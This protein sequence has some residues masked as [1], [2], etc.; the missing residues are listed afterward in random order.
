MKRPNLGPSI[1]RVMK[2]VFASEEKSQAFL[3]TYASAKVQDFLEKANNEGF[4]WDDCRHRASS[5]N[6]E[7]ELLWQCVKFSRF[8]RQ[9]PTPILD[10]NGRP[11]EYRL[12][13]SAHRVLHAIDLNLGGTLQ[14]LTPQLDS[15]EDRQRWLMTSLQEEAITSSMIEGAVVTR[16]AAKEMLRAGRKPRDQSEQMVLNNFETIRWLNDHRDDDLTPNLLRTIQS[17][18]TEATLAKPDAQGRFRREDEAIHIVDEEEGEIVHTPPTA[19]S[20]P[21]RLEALCHFANATSSDHPFVHPALRAILLHFWLAYDHPFCDGNGRTARALF[22]WS[23]LRQGYW[24]TEYLSISSVI[25]QKQRQYYRAFLNSEQDDN[26]L[27]Y[28][29]LFHLE[30]ISEGIALFRKYVDRKLRERKRALPAAV[31]LKLNARQQALLTKA[32][33]DPGTEFTYESHA[34]SHG[35]ALAT[36]RTDLLELEALGYL[37]GNRKGRRFIFLAAPDLPRLLKH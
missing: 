2:E 7:P 34:N 35:I 20:L 8:G 27:T 10:Q 22:Y 16:E 19:S 25:R 26:D 30:V 29:I 3:K 17:K 9:I 24:L 28:F 32:S 11:F 14:T 21:A 13:T 6:L 36:A 4:N 15:A 23:M 33:Q 18:L 31:A 1:R 37:R 12:P 5:V